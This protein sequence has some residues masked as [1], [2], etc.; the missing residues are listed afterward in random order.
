MS[1][2]LQLPVLLLNKADFKSTISIHNKRWHCIDISPVTCMPPGILVVRMTYRNNF[3]FK[4]YAYKTYNLSS[5]R[6][7]EVKAIN[8]LAGYELYR[9]TSQ[10]ATRCPVNYVMS[11]QVL[12][13]DEGLKAVLD[14]SEKTENYYK[15]THINERV[16]VFLPKIS[17]DVVREVGKTGGKDVSTL[18]GLINNTEGLHQLDAMLSEYNAAYAEWKNSLSA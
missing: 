13:E 11:Y 6:H 12:L 10:V 16:T 8:A 18:G 9:L 5:D 1:G 2:G 3:N 4:I 17:I 15:L 7:Y 14:S